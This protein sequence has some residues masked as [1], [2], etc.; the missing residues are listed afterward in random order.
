MKLKLFQVKNLLP[1]GTIQQNFSV[2][3]Q[4]APA[5]IEQIARHRISR[6]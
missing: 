4:I 3:E 5:Q 1:G 6:K 2:I